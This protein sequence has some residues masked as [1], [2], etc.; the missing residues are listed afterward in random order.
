MLAEF[1]A[2]VNMPVNGA[3]RAREADYETGHHGAYGMSKGKIRI[4]SRELLEILAGLRT[5]DDNGRRMSRLLADSRGAQVNPRQHSCGNS[6]PAD[7]RPRS[8]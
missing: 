4:G 8:K 7:F 1:P 6:Q 5:L 2:P 3:L